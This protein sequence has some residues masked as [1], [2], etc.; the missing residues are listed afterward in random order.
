MRSKIL[1]VLQII[2]VIL[3]HSACAPEERDVC[4]YHEDCPACYICVNGSCEL[5]ESQL[6]ACGGCGDVPPEVCG[7]AVDNDCD[8]LTDE[9]CDDP[10]LGVVCD[11]TPV[12]ECV[13]E[14]TLRIYAASGTCENGICEYADNEVRCL[15]GC[16]NGIC[17]EDPCAGVTCDLPPSECYATSG[18]CKKGICHYGYLDGAACNDGNPCTVD[19]SCSSGACNGDA[20]ACSDPPPNFCVDA[21]TMRSY[22]ANGVCDDGA[23][24][25][26]YQ[27]VT[28]THGCVNG[29]CDGDPCADVSC[30]IPPN[31]CYRSPGTCSG[32]VCHYGF[33]DGAAC[34]DGD[35]CTLDD[36][37]LG[38]A[39]G[40]TKLTCTAVPADD[41]LGGD[42]LRKYEGSGSCV[43]GECEYPFQDVACALGCEAGACIECTSRE[44]CVQLGCLVCVEG[45]CVQPPPVC[46]SNTDCC[47]GYN[48]NFGNCIP[49]ETGCQSDD[50]CPDTDYPLCVEGGCVVE[51]VTDIDCAQAGQICEDNHCVEPGM[52]VELHWS[53]T[54][55]DLDLHL[56]DAA[57]MFCV[58]DGGDCYWNNRHP[59]WGSQGDL[60]DDPLLTLDCSRSC[61]E[62][63]IVL[64][65]PAAGT[66]TVMVNYFGQDVGSVDAIVE[67]YIGDDPVPVQLTRQLTAPCDTWTAASV[68]WTDGGAHSVNEDGTVESSC[69]E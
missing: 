29:V 9:G 20:M 28:C 43:A 68:Q 40:G 23:C 61:T 60:T 26:G 33:R 5:D 44:D 22:S 39:C 54:G 4:L 69:C 67:I 41:C 25:Y 52:R 64:S 51:C 47:A 31:D 17:G 55:P 36:V 21:N 66:Y 46:Q 24:G 3:A 38:G 7:D 19:D 58:N 37:C 57:G 56:L 59:D 6:N 16:E 12:N 13:D 45:E 1:I 35:P 49:D 2:P 62:E 15:Q 11:T 34:S 18:V 42:I 14:N 27:D 63:V 53:P 10:C 32:G 50:D 65:Y 48:C 30:D 8:G